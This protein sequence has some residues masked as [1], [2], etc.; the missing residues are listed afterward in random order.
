[1]T[2]WMKGEGKEVSGSE[3]NPGYGQDPTNIR[4][5]GVTQELTEESVDVGVYHRQTYIVFNEL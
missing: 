1:M 3:R 5:G 2:T 4:G